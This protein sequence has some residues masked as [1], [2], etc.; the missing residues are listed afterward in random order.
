MTHPT[1]G[2]PPD[3]EHTPTPSPRHALTVTTWLW[4]AL[5]LAYGLYELVSKATKLF[6][7]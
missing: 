2:A 4:V 7:G 3:P 5:P 6:T 1:P